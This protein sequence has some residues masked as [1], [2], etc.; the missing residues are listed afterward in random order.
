MSQ[1]NVHVLPRCTQC[2]KRK[3]STAAKAL[4]I[5][6][7]YWAALERRQTLNRYTTRTR[8]CFQQLF[9]NALPVVKERAD[10]HQLIGDS[11][12]CRDDGVFI[13]ECVLWKVQT[14]NAGC[15]KEIMA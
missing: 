11:Q 8:N 9:C 4:S 3:H 2:S 13:F 5:K 1:R 7:P 14:G 15:L 10:L 12:C 6:I